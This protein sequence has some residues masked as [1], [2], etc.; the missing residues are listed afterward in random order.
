M[1]WQSLQAVMQVNYFTP[2]HGKELVVC[3]CKIQ[4]IGP[5]AC[6]FKRLFLLGEVW[7]RGYYAW[8]GICIFSKMFGLILLKTRDAEHLNF[9]TINTK[10]SS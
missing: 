1:L 9:P 8:E 4:I 5:W 10:T 2:V 7:I 3:Y 6:I